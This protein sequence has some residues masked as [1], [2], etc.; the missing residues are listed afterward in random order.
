MGEDA[1]SSTQMEPHTKMRWPLRT[2]HS[3]KTAGRRFGDACA[4]YP[5]SLMAVP[6]NRP[7]KLALAQFGFHAH[8]IG[9]AIAKQRPKDEPGGDALKEWTGINGAGREA[10]ETAHGGL[11]HGSQD[12]GD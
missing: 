2:A 7:I 10:Q 6:D 8:H 11:L 3:R 9:I 4:I 5:P 1:R 12:I